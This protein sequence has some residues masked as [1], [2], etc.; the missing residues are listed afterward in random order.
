MN[1]KSVFPILMTVCLIAGCATARFKNVREDNYLHPFA[2]AGAAFECEGMS[3]NDGVRRSKQFCDGRPLHVLE[4]KSH[5]FIDTLVLPVTNTVNHSGN[6]TS[7]YS[8]RSYNYQ[9]SSTYTDYVPMNYTRTLHDVEFLCADNDVFQ[10]TYVFSARSSDSP[11]ICTEVPEV[12]TPG[13]E[14]IWRVA[15]ESGNDDCVNQEGWLRFLSAS[16]DR[17]LH[18]F[19]GPK[20]YER[21]KKLEREMIEK[22]VSGPK[23]DFHLQKALVCAK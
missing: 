13:S 10:K 8:G 5:S 22:E 4:E 21:C 12:F 11:L 14:R 16:R 6:I 18:L 1:Y 15:H 7:N 2:F 20:G 3:C 9:G 17:K 23:A 19:V